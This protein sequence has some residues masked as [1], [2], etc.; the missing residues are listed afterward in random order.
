MTVLPRSPA[1]DERRQL[2]FSGPRPQTVEVAIVMIANRV[3]HQL[4]PLPPGTTKDLEQARTLVESV[5]VDLLSQFQFA[6]CRVTQRQLR[7][8]ERALVD[9][10]LAL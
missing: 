9:Y 5:I 10:L 7:R 2:R 1:P 4:R 6:E 8:I 3:D